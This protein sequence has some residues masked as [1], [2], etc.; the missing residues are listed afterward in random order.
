M[1]V[2][3]VQENKILKAQ[4]REKD[5]QIAALKHELDQ[6]KKLIFGHTSERFVGSVDAQQGS[7]FEDTQVAA[8][9]EA[10]EI[11]LLR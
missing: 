9:V 5:E 10:A 6:L 3:L 8:P 7:L 2:T 4:N 11:S 1:E